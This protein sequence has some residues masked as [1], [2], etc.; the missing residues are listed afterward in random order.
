MSTIFTYSKTPNG[1]SQTTAY[2]SKCFLSCIANCGPKKSSWNFNSN[3]RNF[4]NYS[5]GFNYILGCVSVVSFF[6]TTFRAHIFAH[7]F[8]V[9]SFK[10]TKVRILPN[11]SYCLPLLCRRKL[12]GIKD[13]FF[14]GFT[15]FYYLCVKVNNVVYASCYI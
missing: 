2:G 9:L 14:K 6:R 10:T 13:K 11:I 1:I 12:C 4:T 7:R 15:V 5:A 3:A 8:F